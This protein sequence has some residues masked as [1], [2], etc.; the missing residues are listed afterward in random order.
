MAFTEGLDRGRR[1]AGLS[2]MD[3]WVAYIGLGGTMPETVVQGYL[4]GGPTPPREHDLIAH[5]INERLAD[6]GSPQRMTYV[7]ELSA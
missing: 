6:V 7:E 2:M 1:L 4:G 5:A 3:L